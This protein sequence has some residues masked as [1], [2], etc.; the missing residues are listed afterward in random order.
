MSQLKS[1]IESALKTAFFDILGGNEID[2]EYA[3]KDSNGNDLSAAAKSA[4]QSKANSAAATCAQ[5]IANAIINDVVIPSGEVV[6]QVTGGSG[7]PALGVLNTSTLS[8]TSK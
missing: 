8:V 4:I 3:I 1:D 2:G 7:A 6:V 5:A